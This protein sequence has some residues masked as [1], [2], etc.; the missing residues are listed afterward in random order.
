MSHYKVIDLPPQ[1]KCKAIDNRLCGYCFRLKHWPEDLAV[2][3]TK[4]QV[5]YIS[6]TYRG[7]PGIAS[8]ICSELLDA[9]LPGEIEVVEDDFPKFQ[10][11]FLMSLVD[12][13]LFDTEEEK[14][15]VAESFI[16]QCREMA[17]Q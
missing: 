12:P 10:S 17:S 3:K 1:E 14:L 8:W 13:D 7:E 4:D 6:S 2:C 9:H 16:L 15:Q 11:N 5:C